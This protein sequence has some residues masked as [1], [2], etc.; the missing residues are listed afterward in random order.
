MTMS[1]PMADLPRYVIDASVATKW[2]L[3]DATE[4]HLEI[5]DRVLRDMQ[6]SRIALI[7]PDQIC[8]EVGAAILNA[9]RAR[10]PRLSVAEASL[11]VGEV[12]RWGV[13]YVNDHDL[14]SAAFL[15]GRRWGCSFYDGLYLALAQRLG[16]PL[17]HADN[18]LRN[19]LGDQFPLALW[20]EDY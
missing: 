7:A 16:V 5:A 12:G 2:H 6:E 8:Y 11:T 13:T 19:A 20:I 1:V 10:P 17:I 4:G 15:M 3:K 18:N 9:T 14:I